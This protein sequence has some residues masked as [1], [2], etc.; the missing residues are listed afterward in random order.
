VIAVPCLAWPLFQ[1]AAALGFTGVIVWRL[2][3]SLCTSAEI[4]HLLRVG[5]VGLLF[6]IGGFSWHV[7]WGRSGLDARLPSAL[8]GEEITVKGAVISLPRA[9]EFGIQYYFQIEES[10]FGFTGKV[11]LND[12]GADAGMIRAGQRRNMQVKMKRPHGVANP[13]GFDREASLLRK[14]VDATGYVRIVLSVTEATGISLLRLRQYLFDKLNPYTSQSEVGGLVIALVLGVADQIG[15]E[16]G[17]LFSNTGTSHLFVISGLHVGL[18]AGMVYWLA[19]FC[20]RPFTSLSFLL[21]RQKLATLLAMLA[22][23][24][25]AGLAGFT[26]PT[27]RAVVMS[28]VLM[29]VYLTGRKLPVSLRWLLALAAV[30]SLDPL[31]PVSQG[32]WFSFIAVAAL[33]L[34]I[35]GSQHARLPDSSF[36]GGERE[37]EASDEQGKGIRKEAEKEI[38]AQDYWRGRFSRAVS[39]LSLLMTSQLNVFAALL[40]PLLVWGLPISMLS[41]FINLL[42]IPLLGFVVV[43]LCLLFAVLA[44]LGN[45]L[46]APVFRLVEYLLQSLV[47]GLQL[48]GHW[49]SGQMA[50]LELNALPTGFIPW[51]FAGAGIAL[52]LHPAVGITRWLGVPLLMPLLWSAPQISGVVLSVNVLDI[53]QGLSVLVRTNQ[54]NLIYDTGNGRDSGFSAGR[55]IIAPAL[56][57]MGISTLDMVVVSHGDTDHAGGLNGLL[58]VI[59]VK[60]IVASDDVKVQSRQVADC[61]EVEDWVWDGVEF[62][63]LE[64]PRIEGSSNNNSCVLLVRFGDS[65]VLLPGDVEKEAEYQLLSRYG[66]DLQSTLLIAPHHGSKTSS[67]YPFLKTVKPVQAVFTVGYRNRFNHPAQEILQ[68]YDALGISTYTTSET[69]MLSF[70]ISDGVLGAGDKRFSRGVAFGNAR[71]FRKAQPRYWRCP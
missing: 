24:F 53:G 41:P 28:T 71:A 1:I 68:R 13:G 58:A 25:Y 46:A 21:P 29:A 4:H 30:L 52:Q 64:T 42:A 27:L 54:H 70:E 44:G 56:K 7:Y 39:T 47:G 26:L 40:L 8:E 33:L 60:S 65:A 37:Q 12:Y 19:G 17:E 34:L 62:S 49:D 43:P 23:T 2:F 45:F 22:A 36:D 61:H 50:L 16:Q 6:F 55:S 15:R 63:F 69:G 59:P 51:A 57:S 3:C 31:A 20:L 14:G 9:T 67:S 11:L 10:D 5:L 35:D 38:G 32:F 66:T 18:V 48:I